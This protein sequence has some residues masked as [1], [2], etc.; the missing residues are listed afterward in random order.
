M[1]PITGFNPGADPGIAGIIVD[2]NNLV[3]QGI[4]LSHTK[5]EQYD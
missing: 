2:C 3:P 4:V 5:G 1:T